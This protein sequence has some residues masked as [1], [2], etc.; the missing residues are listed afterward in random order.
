M[1]SHF[2]EDGAIDQLDIFYLGV[3][4]NTSRFRDTIELGGEISPKRGST[5]S[6]RRY[7]GL[8]CACTCCHARGGRTERVI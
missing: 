8:A 7:V 1:W 2:L 5:I 3:H 6:V 4:E